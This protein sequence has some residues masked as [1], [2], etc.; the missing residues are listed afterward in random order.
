MFIHCTTYTSN[1]HSILNPIH[2]IRPLLDVA[3]MEPDAKH[4]NFNGFSYN[5]LVY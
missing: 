3:T 5:K 4:I 1:F 2:H